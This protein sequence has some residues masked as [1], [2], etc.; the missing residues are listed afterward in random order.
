MSDHLVRIISESGTIRGLACDTTDLVEYARKQHETDPTATVAL[1]RALTGG[2]LLGALQ[3][4]GHRVNL[5]FEGNGPLGKIVV[6]ADARGNVRGYTGEPHVAVPPAGDR[7]DVAS[8][9]GRA[10]LLTVTK[11]IGMREPYR[12]TV[13]LI[14]GEIGEDL[15]YYFVESEQIPSAVGLGAQLAPDGSVAV[16]GGFL[17]QAIP[18]GDQGNVESITTRI[19]ALAPYTNI[20]REGVSP[21]G[22]LAGM[23]AEVPF[24]RLETV[25][26]K[27]QCPCSR[28][29]FER[30][31][32]TLGPDEL[33]DMAEKMGE[34]ETV[35]EFC[36][37]KYLF[38]KNDLLRIAEAACGS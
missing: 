5:K 37:E 35:C 12:S 7:F 24:E 36:H 17:I 1:G 18:P 29:R 6:E 15:A 32:V 23:F 28:E 19:S 14:S 9:I 26:L 8:A 22:A 3:K 25:P 20:L 27:Y 34:I 11:D 30:A 13:H 4:I 2:I 16:A 31:L 21:E 10:G 33:S 38:G